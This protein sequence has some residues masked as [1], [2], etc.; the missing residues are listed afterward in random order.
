MFIFSTTQSCSFEPSAKINLT[1]RGKMLFLPLI[2]AAK[3]ADMG[4]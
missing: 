2:D 3:A 4:V 1:C